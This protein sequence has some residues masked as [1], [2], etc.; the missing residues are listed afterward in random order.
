MGLLFIPLMI[1]EYGEPWWNYIDRGK[2]K[3]SEKTYP[4]ATS[5]AANPTCTDLS[6]DLG[7]CSE[8]LVTNRLSHSMALAQSLDLAVW[9]KVY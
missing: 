7:R 6:M 1:Y 5:T 9:K 2:L 3:N 4:S 8:R